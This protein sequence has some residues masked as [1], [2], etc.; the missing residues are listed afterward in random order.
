MTEIKKPHI[1]QWIR[2]ILFIQVGVSAALILGSLGVA[3][4]VADSSL[5]VASALVSAVLILGLSLLCS[6]RFTRLLQESRLAITQLTTID[7]LT[8]LPNRRRFFDYLDQEVSRAG[9]YGN[10][11]SLIMI[12]IDHFQKVNDTFGH[13]LGDMALSQVA[14]LLDA[15]VRTSDIVARYGGEE[16][17][18]LLPETTADQAAV[19]AEKLRMVVEVNDIS[20]E[21]PQVKVTVSCGVA[22]L[23]SITNTKRT[24]RDVF[25]LSVDK[26]LRRAKNNGRNQVSMFIPATNKQLPLV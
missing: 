25:I 3:L 16:F 17:M 22:D 5:A 23:A 15:N 13:P 10:P 1:R 20:L 4:F 11:L 18:V 9:R 8:G 19:V 14:R 7:D 21:G 12:D 24:L 2:K 26:S 6:S